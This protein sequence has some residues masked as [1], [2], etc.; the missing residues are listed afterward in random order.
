MAKKN[1]SLLDFITRFLKTIS[2]RTELIFGPDLAAIL[3]TA[4]G[5]SMTLHSAKNLTNMVRK[6]SKELNLVIEKSD[7]K[8]ILFGAN[9]AALPPN[10]S[11]ETIAD[12]ARKIL[13][14]INKCRYKAKNSQASELSKDPAGTIRYMCEKEPDAFS[15]KFDDGL[16][17]TITK[18]GEL[19]IT[20]KDLD[21]QGFIIIF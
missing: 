12:L 15:V 8:M 2:A 14:G 18:D 17:V 20:R 6:I 5:S 13:D 21:R 9:V 4:T 11:D 7:G 19:Y 16:L 1:S 3:R 10:V